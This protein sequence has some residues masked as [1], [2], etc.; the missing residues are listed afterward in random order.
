MGAW[1]ILN[2]ECSDLRS[3]ERSLT[4]GFKTLGSAQ[5]LSQYMLQ[6]KKKLKSAGQINSTSPQDAGSCGEG[7]KSIKLSACTAV[8]LIEKISLPLSKVGPQVSRKMRVITDPT[9]F[10]HFFFSLP[11]PYRHVSLTPLEER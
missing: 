7:A 1:Q 5:D 6:F 2:V 8:F 10:I 9:H 11:G 3:R 4:G